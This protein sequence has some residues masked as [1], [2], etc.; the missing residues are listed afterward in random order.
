MAGGDL[1]QGLAPC[2]APGTLGLP[3]LN[4]A[5]WYGVPRTAL[6]RSRALEGAGSQA[7]VLRS[8][9]SWLLGNEVEREETWQE[10]LPTHSAPLPASGGLWG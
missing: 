1:A 7:A 5:G 9:N 10:A 2:W 4:P 6:P 8:A 3:S